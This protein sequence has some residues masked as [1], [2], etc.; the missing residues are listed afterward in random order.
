[1]AKQNNRNGLEIEA[2]CRLAEVGGMAAGLGDGYAHVVYWMESSGVPVPPCRDGVAQN[3]DLDRLGRPLQRG[4][5]LGLFDD[6]WPVV[7]PALAGHPYPAIIEM[8]PVN[9]KG[10][11]SDAYGNRDLTSGKWDADAD[12]PKSGTP[13]AAFL[14]AVETGTPIYVCLLTEV[15]GV[16]MMRRADASKVWA[17]CIGKGA[18]FICEAGVNRG[19]A[20]PVCHLRVFGSGAY[21]GLYRRARIEWRHVPASLWLDADFVP[22]DANAPLPIPYI[23]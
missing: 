17:E 9:F 16:L 6:V 13:L 3:G 22:F 10:S 20:L 21:A 8:V 2:G 15:D 23:E 7:H 11:K 4:R 19:K 14:A 1:M 5:G 18:T 12:A